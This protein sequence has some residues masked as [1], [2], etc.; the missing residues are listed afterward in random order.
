[1][2][3]YE[4]SVGQSFLD[5]RLSTE[6]TLFYIDGKNMIQVTRIDGKAEECEYRSV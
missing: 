2:M 6:L 3:N 4:V 1:M 5:N